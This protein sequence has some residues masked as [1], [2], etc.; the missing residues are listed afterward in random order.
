MTPAGSPPGSRP[1]ASARATITGYAWLFILLAVSAYLLFAILARVWL[2]AAAVFG[3][4]VITAL[5]RPVV[6]LFDRAMPRA[7]AVVASLAAAAA[8]LLGLLA[9]IGLSVAGKVSQLRG[10][11]HGGVQKLTGWLH[12]SP[13][14]LDPQ[15]VDR[16]IGQARHWL[17]Q[18]KGEI[19]GHAL[20]GAG[21]AAEALTGVLIALFC[22][23]FFLSS[24]DRMWAWCLQQLPDAARGRWGAG[25]RAG[26]TTFQA[27]A[28]AT[29][30]VA[31]SNAALVAVALLVLRVPLA[32][33]LALVVFLASFVP[34]VGGAF[35]LAAAALIALA[36][37]GPVVAL[38]VLVLVPVLGQVEGHVLQP[39]IMS[40]S[41]RVHPV[42]V[43]VAVVSGGLLGGIVGAVVAVPLVAVAWSV[44]KELRHRE[45]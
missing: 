24:G 28:R 25:A 22:A 39:L 36:A 45:P 30:L 26:W 15:Q 33:P 10:Q 11:F 9:V 17:T 32:L 6:D 37:R 20:G 5:L 35:S 29:V 41:V 2:A 14:H 40:R 1:P 7:L 31:A 4:L 44:F 21:T 43:V 3:A 23:V 12:A 8:V 16:G 18:H 19:A 13:L 42:V 38:I 27:Y 34:V